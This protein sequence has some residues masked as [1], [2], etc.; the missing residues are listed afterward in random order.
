MTHWPSGHRT[1][2]S[3]VLPR[4]LETWAPRW[5]I[6]APL[7]LLIKLLEATTFPGTQI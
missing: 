1:A 2:A 5:S 7:L 3:E 6:S 4:L